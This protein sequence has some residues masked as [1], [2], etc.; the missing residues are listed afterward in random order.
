MMRSK[1][2]ITNEKNGHAGGCDFHVAVRQSILHERRIN[3]F[4]LVINFRWWKS[5]FT[6]NHTNVDRLLTV[7]GDRLSVASHDG[8]SL[9]TNAAAFLPRAMHYKAAWLIH[10]LMMIQ[11]PCS[12]PLDSREKSSPCTQ[13]E[14]TESC[15]NLIAMNIKQTLFI[16]LIGSSRASKR[17]NS[18]SEFPIGQSKAKMYK[19][20]LV[21]LVAATIVGM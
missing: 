1:A 20:L 16:N 21:A 17:R 8:F 5:L 12:P 4:W 13:N 10:T 9:R 2:S 18:A 3:H 7:V 19:Y 6:T 15:T 11:L 14:V